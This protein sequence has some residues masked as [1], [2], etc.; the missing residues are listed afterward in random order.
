MKAE[1]TSF[2]MVS[3]MLLE[4]EHINRKGMFYPIF[5][6]VSRLFKVVVLILDTITEGTASQIFHLD[7]SSYFM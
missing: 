3:F 1:Y 5:H 7:P 6:I 4:L 2:L